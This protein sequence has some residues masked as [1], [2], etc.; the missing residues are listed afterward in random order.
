MC[1]YEVIWS[2]SVQNCLISINNLRQK[3]F[4]LHK[5][6][7]Q[8][9]KNCYRF[10]LRTVKIHLWHKL[11]LAKVCIRASETPLSCNSL[12]MQ[13]HAS[14]PHNLSLSMFH[15]VNQAFQ[16]KSIQLCCW[17]LFKV[18]T[19]FVKWFSAFLFYFISIRLFTLINIKK[20]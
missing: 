19:D 6:I 5:Y 1:L 14:V 15:V 9:R 8:C 3:R 20:L 12:S 13:P 2:E 10:V 11:N 17:K 4:F 16:T 7:N 18:L